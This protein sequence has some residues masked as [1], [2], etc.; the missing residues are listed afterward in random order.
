VSRVAQL[1]FLLVLIAVLVLLIIGIQN[2]TQVDLRLLFWTVPMNAA[3]L[4]LL[5]FGAGVVCGMILSWML[6]REKKPKSGD[7]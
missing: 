3:L 1:K 2:R 7:L 4:Y 5:L 6:R